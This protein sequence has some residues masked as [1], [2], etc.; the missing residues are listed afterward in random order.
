MHLSQYIEMLNKVL[1]EHGDHEVAITQEG[2]YSDGLFA[3]LYLP[4][5]LEE[6]DVGRKHVWVDGVSHQTP[7]DRRKF[8]VLGHSY[9]NY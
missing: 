3:D 6:I 8:I 2:Y 9:Q 4:A 1:E 5:E 7:S